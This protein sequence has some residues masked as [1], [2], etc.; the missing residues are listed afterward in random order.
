MNETVGL[1][2]AKARRRSATDSL[3][4]EPEPTEPGE[5]KQTGLV[6]GAKGGLP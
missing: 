6:Q 3:S 4:A 5:P 1:S 2:L